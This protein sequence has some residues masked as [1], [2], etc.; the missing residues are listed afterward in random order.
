MARSTGVIGVYSITQA[1]SEVTAKR[2]PMMLELVTDVFS[3]N[4][5]VLVGDYRLW[6]VQA[7]DPGEILEVN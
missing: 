4:I 6:R 3:C 2:K 5:F 1:K 7:L